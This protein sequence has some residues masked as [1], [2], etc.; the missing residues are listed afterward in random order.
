M[1]SIQKIASALGAAAWSL[2]LFTT[3]QSSWNGLI[4]SLPKPGRSWMNEQGSPGSA[5]NSDA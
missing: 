4:A 1:H 3:R 2:A 5:M